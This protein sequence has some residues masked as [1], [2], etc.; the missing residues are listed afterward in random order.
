M[1]DLKKLLSELKLFWPGALVAA[2]LVLVPLSV[3]FLTGMPG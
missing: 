3:Q 2:A 1:N